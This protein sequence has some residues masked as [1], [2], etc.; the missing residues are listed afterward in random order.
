[1]IFKNIKQEKVLI[2]Q[3]KKKEIKSLTVLTNMF[4]VNNNKTTII[5]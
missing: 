3:K 2:K 1:M 4:V 5:L